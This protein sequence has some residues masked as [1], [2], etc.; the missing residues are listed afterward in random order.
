MIWYTVPYHLC[1][2]EFQRLLCIIYFLSYG[3]KLQSNGE[4]TMGIFLV[5]LVD[6]RGH[7]KLIYSSPRATS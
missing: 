3:M 5:Q 7:M 6:M 4:N 1:N 2:V